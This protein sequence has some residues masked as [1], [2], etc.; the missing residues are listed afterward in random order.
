MKFT[1]YKIESNFVNFYIDSDIDRTV[2][3]YFECNNTKKQF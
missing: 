2:E 3:E 1:D